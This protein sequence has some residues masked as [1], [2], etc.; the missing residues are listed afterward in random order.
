MAAGRGD[1]QETEDLEKRIQMETVSRDNK[2]LSCGEGT[3]IATK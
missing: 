2:R 1:E 3:V